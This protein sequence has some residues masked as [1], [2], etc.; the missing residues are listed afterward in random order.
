MKLSNVPVS[1]EFVN[2]YKQ[3]F[4]TWGDTV[5]GY[6]F[7]WRDVENSESQNNCYRTM[8]LFQISQNSE[9]DQSFC[10]FSITSTLLTSC[11]LVFTVF[12]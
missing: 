9:S 2:T 1:G 10:G 3:I 11:H 6:D 5:Y 12:G 7:K 4:N 8:F